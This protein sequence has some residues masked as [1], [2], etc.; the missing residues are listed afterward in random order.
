[1]WVRLRAGR[2]DADHSGDARGGHA[3][4]LDETVRDHGRFLATVGARNCVCHAP[5]APIPSSEMRPLVDVARASRRLRQ[6]RA[7]LRCLG[8]MARPGIQSVWI[9]FDPAPVRTS[10]V[11]QV[12]QRNSFLP[13]SVYRDPLRSAMCSIHERA[14]LINRPRLRGSTSNS[15]RPNSMRCGTR[16]SRTFY[17]IRSMQSPASFGKEGMTPRSIRLLD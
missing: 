6:H 16:S 15:R 11:R 3:P 14:S 17:S 12:Q 1:V 5:W 9:Q 7:D 13:R 10:L 4:C 2:C 8:C